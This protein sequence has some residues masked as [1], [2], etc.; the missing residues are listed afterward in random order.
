MQKRTHLRYS[1]LI[2]TK[3]CVQGI[4]VCI[5][6]QI[7]LYL[8]RKAN[9]VMLRLHLLQKIAYIYIHTYV[10]TYYIFVVVYSRKIETT[11]KECEKYMCKTCCFN[12]YVCIYIYIFVCIYV[13]MHV[14]V[15]I[16]FKV[17]T[18]IS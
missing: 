5:Y 13:C 12:I 4:Y 11:T 1:L 2:C 14:C 8:Y 10:Y 15:Y 9:L 3:I 7:F 18:A 6:K 16:C 17:A